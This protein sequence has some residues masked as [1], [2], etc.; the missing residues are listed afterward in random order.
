VDIKGFKSF[1]SHL[2]EITIRVCCEAPAVR[3][4]SLKMVSLDTEMHQSEN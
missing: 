2:Y 3:M 4:N 1:Q